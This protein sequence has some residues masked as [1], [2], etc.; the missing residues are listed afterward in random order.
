MSKTRPRL[1]VQMDT[2]PRPQ[3]G[4]FR[5]GGPVADTWAQKTKKTVPAMRFYEKSSKCISL[6]K[7]SEAV[8]IGYFFSDGDMHDNVSPHKTN[9][10]HR[11]AIQAK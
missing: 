11:A 10:E 1:E 4:D 2:W 8:E 7:A 5:P 6:T 9:R 3:Q